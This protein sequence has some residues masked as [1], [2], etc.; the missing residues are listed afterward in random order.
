MAEMLVADGLRKVYGEE[1]QTI[2]LDRV[3][4]T[5]QRGEFASMIGQSGS[6]KS[7][8][9]NLIGLLDTPSD[10]VPHERLRRLGV[11]ALAHASPRFRRRRSASRTRC[12]RICSSSPTAMS[13]MRMA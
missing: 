10:A 2:A 12:N 13:G 1:Y 4:F 6:G 5:L 11:A 8:L 9:L 7:T 3:S